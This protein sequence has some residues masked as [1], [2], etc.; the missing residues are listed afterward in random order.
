MIWPV[1]VGGY[2]DDGF[3]RGVWIRCFMHG[4]MI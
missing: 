2:E 1:Y 3:Q 4:S